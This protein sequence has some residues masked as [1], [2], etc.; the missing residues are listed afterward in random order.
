MKTLDQ[1]NI[2][3]RSAL[4]T[5]GASGIGLA[6]AE[7]M[8]EAGAK[9]TI[10]DLDSDGAEREAARMR[11]EGAEIQAV[12]CDISDLAQVTAAFDAHVAAYG[13]LDICFANAGWDAGD[14]FW[15]PSGERNP[16]GRIDQYDPEKWKPVSRLREARFG[17]RS[18]VGQDHAQTRCHPSRTG[19]DAGHLRMTA[20][21]RT[22]SS[23]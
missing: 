17:G 20:R 15:A 5:G 10:A 8:A 13:G 7:A 2:T 22:R 16:L 19:E 1:F 9:V 12:A 14:G 4:V 18:K 11:G 23:S 6:Y 3:G 21:D